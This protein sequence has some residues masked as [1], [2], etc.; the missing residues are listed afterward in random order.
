LGCCENCP[1]QYKFKYV[2]KVECEV[3]E[4]VEAFMGK[5]VHETLEKLYTD[6]KFQRIL[7]L[8]E[9]KEYLK[10]NWKKNW[11]ETIRIVKK[12]YKEEDY[13]K[14][15]LKFIEDYYESNKPFNDGVTIGTEMRIVINLDN[16]GKYKLQGYIDRLN[17]INNEEYHIIDYKTNSHL[18]IQEQL[19][20]DRQLALYQTA[21]ENTFKDAKKILLKWHFLA[22]NKALTSTRTKQELK[23]LKIDTIK[24]IKRIESEKDYKPIK[25]NL[26]DWCEFRGIC[27]EWSHLVSLESKTA[28]QYLEDD[29]VKLVN[30]YIK[31]SE[32]RRAIEK[33]LDEIKQDLISFSK[34]KGVDVVFGSNNKIKVKI[35]ESY[36]FP[37]KGSKEREKLMEFLKKIKKLEEVIDIDIFALKKVMKEESW[38]E[39]E[40]KELKKFAEKTETKTLYASK[41]SKE[42]E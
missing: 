37:K 1:L 13:L 29:G 10:T 24:L 32:Q 25:S 8:N 27:P 3:C 9:L 31:L 28:K 23:Q 21:V 35:D 26:C 2:D 14:M 36:T 22:F 7:A 15:A 11:N 38:T 41:I 5:R 18:K 33:Q 39:K 19:D 34:Q 12:E 6:L 4:G 17:C 20:N 30:N 16:K 40:L 42:E